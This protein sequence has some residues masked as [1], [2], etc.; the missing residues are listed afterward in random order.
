MVN[1]LKSLLPYFGVTLFFIAITVAYFWPVLEGKGIEQLDNTKA[2]GMAKELID[3]EKETGE[4]AQWTNSLFS[5][6]PAYQIRA[7]SS[8][9]IYYHLNNYSR[10]GLPYHTVAIVFLYLIGFYILLKSMGFSHILSIT[11]SIAFAFGSYNFIII[12][13][14]HITKAYVM[15][16]MAPVL[17]GVLYTFNRNQWAGA[18]ITTVAL[19]AN[20]AYNHVQ[21]TYYLALLV[22]IL[23]LTRLV[24]AIQEKTIKEYGR[25]IAVLA[26]AAFLAILP[27][28]TNLW[29]T[30]EYG[31]ESIRGTSPIAAEQENKERSSSG[32]DPDYAFAWSYGKAETL[33][34]LI[35]NFMGGASEPIG[36]NSELT[37]NLPQRVAERLQQE[38]INLGEQQNQ[39]INQLSNEIAG[40]SQ[41]WG[42]KPF[43]SGPVY[44]GALVC[45][46][47]VLS[48]FIYK[49]K[50]KWWLLG[51][52]ILSILLAWGHNLEWFNMFMFNYFPLYNKFRTVE[53]ALVIA[54]VTIPI[55]AVLGLNK[56]IKEPEI[57]TENS[58]KFMAALGLTAGVS[59]IF[60]LFPNLLSFMNEHEMSALT[61]QQ[62]SN[63]E[64]AVI[65]DIIIS[66]LKFARMTLLKSDAFRSLIF[67][68]LGSGGIW[69]FAKGK[70]GA[71]YLLPA[72]AILI[73]VDLWGVNKRYI[74]NDHFVP[75]R[76]IEQTFTAKDADRD[77]MEDEE[78]YFRVFAINRNAF[79]ETKTSY[80]HKSIG[81]YHGA[82]L[83]RYQDVID[84]YLQTYRQQLTS[85]LQ[86]SHNPL[87]MEEALRDMPA[88]N[89]LNSKYIIFHSDMSPL[90]NPYRMGNAWLVNDIRT[91]SSNLEELNAIEQFDLHQTAVV[92][93]EFSNV[94][95]NYTIG[96]AGGNID[97]T[98]YSPDEL[99]YNA[100]SNSSQLALFSEIYYPKGWRAYINGV[101]APIVRANYLLR[102]VFVPEGESEIVM[103][104]EP[105]SYRWGKTIAAVSSFIIL[106][107][108]GGYLFKRYYFKKE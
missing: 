59:L 90:Q 87:S 84:R 23:L 62:M 36:A 46:L 102:G 24:K 68:A 76:E 21:I 78:L 79:N 44:L 103:K 30:W 88:L 54:S 10:L 96:E 74:N 17:A 67:I 63:P 38:G 60:Y 11:G 7:D 99:H 100:Q 93:D 18:L 98:Y 94:L 61:G 9:N 29:T 56:I 8:A 51:G 53:M 6:M 92:H 55:L 81:G 13:A 12:I 72:I 19:G 14:G 34:F 75:K 42:S 25:R 95:Q 85:L 35:P 22:L 37:A 58:G 49:G 65:Y 4:K 47:F 64:Q 16:L 15:A 32:L 70:I 5:G 104:F 77:I 45:F 71:K 41:Y 57:V 39:F 97:L 31:Q 73:L 80:F 82:K 106:F 91:V 86:E 69:Y 52:T 108:I 20:I 89:M 101:E 1:R 50:E 83:Q 40:Q 105:A 43:T 66:E 28:I 3:H 2:I 26:A 107:L 33:T 27:N 48:L